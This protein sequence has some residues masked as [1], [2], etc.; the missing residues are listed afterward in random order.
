MKAKVRDMEE[1]TREVRNR[2]MRKYV[3][4]C[5]KDVIGKKK[6]LVQL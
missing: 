2:R 1:K 6:L 5:V 4:G 3:V